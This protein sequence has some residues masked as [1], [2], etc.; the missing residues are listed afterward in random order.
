M[1]TVWAGAP[2]KGSRGFQ[3]RWPV[4]TMLPTLSDDPQ[5]E[6]MFLDGAALASKIHH[7]NDG[8]D[9]STSARARRILYLRHVGG[10]TAKRFSASSTQSGPQEQYP[11]PGFGSRAPRDHP[12]L[13]RP[14]FFA[15]AHEAPDENTTSRSSS[16]TATSPRKSIPVT[17]DGIGENRVDFGVREDRGAR[18][19]RETDSRAQPFV[20]AR[21]EA[22]SRGGNVDRRTDVFTDK[23]SCSTA[24]ADDDSIRSSARTI[25]SLRNIISRPCSHAPRENPNY[26]QRGS[27]RSVR[28]PEGDP[29]K[30]LPDGVDGTET[31]S[32]APSRDPWVSP[33]TTSGGFVHFTFHGRSRTKRRC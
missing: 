19:R 31:R 16:S 29:E 24:E 22:L 2:E 27:S 20:T 30:A 8:G 15:R 23:A 21:T 10:S 7:P 18:R 3:K 11:A 17:Y 5:F 14:P 12:G 33:T 28:V 4:K 1:A 13:R 9:H 25:S 26:P 32:S 6:Q